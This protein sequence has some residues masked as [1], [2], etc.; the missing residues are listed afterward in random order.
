[1]PQPKSSGSDMTQNPPAGRQAPGH[2][3]GHS[4]DQGIMIDKL[5]QFDIQQEIAKADQRRPWPAG[6]LAQTLFKKENFR[7]VLI[8]MEP[9]KK[10]SEHH[11]DGALSVQVIKGQIQFRVPDKTEV[12]TAGNLLMLDA[13]I[14]HDLEAQSEA[15][16]LLTIGWPGGEKLESLPH[17]GY[18]S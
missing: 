3:A 17:R 9:G 10:I 2:A 18:G 1:M 15:A 11:A 6:I 13:S 12:L 7:V 8:I 14:R 5:L 16:F 4:D